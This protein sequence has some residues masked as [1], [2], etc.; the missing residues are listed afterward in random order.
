MLSGYV[1]SYFE[2]NKVLDKSGNSLKKF[3]LGF[4]NR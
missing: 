1:K 2:P 3:F 4:Y